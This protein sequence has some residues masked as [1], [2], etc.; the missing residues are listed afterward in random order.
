M[1][2]MSRWRCARGK[3]AD[4]PRASL[5]GKTLLFHAT[6]ISTAAVLLVLVS[7]AGADNL[8][9]EA[10]EYCN[11]ATCPAGAITMAG[12]LHPLMGNSTG[13]Q[14]LRA[15][16]RLAMKAVQLFG[17][18]RNPSIGGLHLSFQYLCCYNQTELAGISRAIRAVKWEK[19]PVTFTRIVCAGSEFVALASP[20]AQ[21]ALFGVVSAFEEAM[22][23]AGYPVHRFRAAQFAFH[24]SLFQ[25]PYGA[26][27]PNN[28]Y[29]AMLA[30][31]NAALPPGGLNTEP[32]EVASFQGLAA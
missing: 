31:A 1:T 2:H 30:A 6:S 20:A 5:G 10:A 4:R 16:V 3:T 11:A 26:Q 9:C 22:A 12:T 14:Q 27:F 32:I 7:R 29:T 21:G 18:L 8:N 15:S 19:V 17:P 24:A 13:E 23:Q 25:P 28:S